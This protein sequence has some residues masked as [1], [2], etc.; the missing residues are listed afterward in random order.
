MSIARIGKGITYIAF[1]NAIQFVVGI[2]FYN[3]LS[4]TLEPAE[5]GVYSTLTFILVILTTVAP[6]ALQF[7]AV[8]YVSTYLGN[9]DKNKAAQY[10][11]RRDL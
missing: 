9:G 4:R 1:L 7:A 11:H 5:I 10:F 8:K 6:L 3:I 2:L